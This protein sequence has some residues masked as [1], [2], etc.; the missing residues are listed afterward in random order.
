MLNRVFSNIFYFF[1]RKFIFEDFPKGGFDLFLLD[2]SLVPILTNSSKNSYMPILL[3]WIGVKP[4]V[5]KY[6]RLRR[7]G[8]KSQWSFEKRRKA[9]ID[10]LISYSQKPVRLIIRVSF[11]ICGFAFSYGLLVLASA[12]FGRREVPGFAST[13]VF[14][15]FLGAL[16]IMLIS[17]VLAYQWRILEQLDPKPRTVITRRRRS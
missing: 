11:V 12:L 13:L 1:V 4:R 9:F 6:E 7:Y 2:E 10:S 15:S 3:W 14:I 17:L 16:T 8:G 5:L